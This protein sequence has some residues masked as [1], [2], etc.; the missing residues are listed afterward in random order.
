[1]KNLLIYIHPTKSFISPKEGWL[2]EADIL[3]KVQ[4]DNSLH[5]GW[6]REDILL[7][8]NFDYEYNGVKAI[9]IG[10]DNFCEVSPTASKI[11]AILTLFDDG[12]IGKDL[13]WFHD[14]DAFQ[15]APMTEEEIDL[16][17]G[18]IGLTGYGVTR[19][20]NKDFFRWSTGTLFFR[21][22][23]KDVFKLLKDAVYN[24]KANEE[25]ALLALRRTNKLVLSRLQT[26]DITYNLA[27][28][29][30]D[31]IATYNVAQKPL[32]VIHFHPFDKRLVEGESDNMDVCVRG[33]N[34]INKVLVSEKLI[35]LFSQYGIK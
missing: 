4:I 3:A 13:Y 1:M 32:K 21:D 6:K 23:I 30:R 10:D 11:N 22:D 31:V 2:G 16:K 28:R 7:V 25:V 18:C 34:S 29:K 5:L 19:M 35:E 15:L 24:Y 8:T 27:T 33:K 12:M 26:L 20:R 9:V 14:W 17:K